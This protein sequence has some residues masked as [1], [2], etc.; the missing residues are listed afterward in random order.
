[1]VWAFGQDASW[2]LPFGEVP[3]SSNWQETLG[4][5]QNT[6]EGLHISTGQGMLWDPPGG[7]CQG[8]LTQTDATVILSLTENGCVD[9]CFIRKVD[10]VSKG[11]VAIG[12]DGTSPGRLAGR[13]RRE[14]YAE[15]PSQAV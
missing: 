15:R 5:T 7:C 2:T 11:G 12:R 9:T 6:L 3:G 1:M 13:R 8:F 14:Y 10:C 4:Q